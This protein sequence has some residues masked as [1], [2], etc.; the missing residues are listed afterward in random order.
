MSCADIQELLP[1]YSLGLLTTQE[2]AEIQ[3]HLATGCY[4]CQAMLDELSEAA[5]MIPLTDQHASKHLAPPAELKATL[6]QRVRDD[7]LQG[8]RDSVAPAVEPSSPPTSHASSRWKYVIGYAAAAVIA[9]VIGAQF[10]GPPQPRVLTQAE[11][12]RLYQ[13]RMAKIQKSF[14]AE[15]IHL[16][17]ATRS[18]NLPDKQGAV[19]WDDQAR[20]VHL[21]AFD[22][23][24]TEA[25]RVL[26]VWIVD[27]MGIYLPIG[28]LKVDQRGDVAQVFTVPDEIGVVSSILVTE[29]AQPATSTIPAGSRPPGEVRL[30]APFEQQ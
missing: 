23:P 21:F 8:K 9:F 5:A 2:A 4:H 27:A 14:D 16:A 18:A 20:Q 12:E 10:T 19:V 22:L 17:T 30:I 29:E 25:N 24:T 11:R 28:T 3:S 7:A 6:M 13:E 1:E 26:Q 15:S